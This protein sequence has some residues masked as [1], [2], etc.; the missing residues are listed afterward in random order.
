MP[1][2]RLIFIN[3]Y[4]SPDH[5][6]TAQILAD[7]TRRLA[8]RGHEVHVIT[9][10]S[11]YSDPSVVL[12][13]RE[14][15]DGATVTRVWTSRFGRS[16][17]AGRAMDYLSFYPTM[18]LALWRLARRGDVV[19]AKTDPP[20]LSVAAAR[21]AALRGARLVNWLQDLYPEVAAALG[22]GA[23]KGPAGGLAR[24]L[25]NA[26]LR[27]AAVNVAIGEIMAGRLSDEGLAAD[28]IAVIPNW[29]DDEAIT[30]QALDGGGLRD[31]WGLA[32]GDFV[33]GYSGN[34][35]QAHEVET[36]FGAAE[37]LRDQ[38]AIK[39]LFVGGGRHS[40]GLKQRAAEAGLTNFVFQPYQL[41]ERL[42]QSLA[43]ADVHWLSLRPEMEGLIVPSKYYGI[44]A[45]GRGA[46]VVAAPEG[47]LGS[48]VTREGG[49]VAV[50]PGD[51]DGLT[52]AIRALEA[53]R[54]ACAAM[55]KRARQTLEARFT[56]AASLERWERLL[57]RVAAG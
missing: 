45:A 15:V 57:A 54:P 14:A 19:I 56:K 39:F 11:L 7:L 34:L 30:P 9:S 28:R 37:R 4:F 50:A 32:A 17:L 52:E 41:R 49:G 16:N 29:S 38:P 36:L 24:A 3:R 18:A 21:V 22:M 42:A 13:A 33:V 12:A 43:V 5:S 51:V 27:A 25:R 40:D 23:L 26:S 1:A 10:R 6:A 46:I 8:A 48:L 47:E 55:G 31:Q 20:L 2:P 44:A 53:D 35:G